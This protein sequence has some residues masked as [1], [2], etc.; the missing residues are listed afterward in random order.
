M[1]FWSSIP[2]FGISV[3]S[4]N[5]Y[6]FTCRFERGRVIVR[7]GHIGRSLYVVFNG[8]VAMLKDG[9]EEGLLS[10]NTSEQE[11]NSNG[12]S[13]NKTIL[14]K[15]DSFGVRQPLIVLYLKGLWGYCEACLSVYFHSLSILEPLLLRKFWVFPLV[16]LFLA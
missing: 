11:E 2:P 3:N 16:C 12:N 8:S 13:S 4:I 10:E 7:K 9:N 14:K 15:G 6:R 5:H 1:P